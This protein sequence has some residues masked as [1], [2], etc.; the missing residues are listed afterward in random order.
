MVPPS[1]GDSVGSSGQGIGLSE[2]L[3]CSG[4]VAPARESIALQYH[5]AGEHTYLLWKSSVSKRFGVDARDLFYKRRVYWGDSLPS[6][7][8]RAESART[9]V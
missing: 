7:G 5:R 3:L 9:R 6:T 8:A 2:V 1:H 4:M